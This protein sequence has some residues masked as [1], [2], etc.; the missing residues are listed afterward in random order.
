[1]I[2][3][4]Q[5]SAKAIAPCP[6]CG[7]RRTRIGVVPDERYSNIRIDLYRCGSCGERSEE[8]VLEAGT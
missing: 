2:E 7:G 8:A 4:R 6:K 3:N 5:T 1:M